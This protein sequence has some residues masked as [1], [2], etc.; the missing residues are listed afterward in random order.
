MATLRSLLLAGLAV[1]AVAVT[2]LPVTGMAQMQ[3][4]SVGGTASRIISEP[5]IGKRIAEL[6][7][8]RN[9]GVPVDISFHGSGNELEVPANSTGALKVDNFSFDNRS[10]RFFAVVGVSGGD[11]IKVSG[12]AQTVEAIPVLRTRVAANQTIDRND[13]E[14]MRVPSGRYGAGYVDRVEDLLGQAPRRALAAGAP[15]RA[16]DITKPAAITKN[17]LV[18]M[19]A[20]GP[21]MTLTT[22]GRAM[23]TGSVGDVI[24]V[25]N[26]QSKKTVQATVIAANQVQ[27]ITAARVIASN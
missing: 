21:G 4:A 8:Q 2:A 18:T 24:A 7:Q 25:M 15:I 9:G 27:V 12:R 3:V 16:A 26:V 13:I 17:A 22:T 6:V 10:G 5:E 20:Q 14:W 11:L 1:S 23:E 19:V